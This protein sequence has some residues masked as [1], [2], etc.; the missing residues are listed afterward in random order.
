MDNVPVLKDTEFSQIAELVYS[1]F[2]IHL[3]EQKR[4]LVAGRLAKRLRDLNLT[5]YGDYLNF[6]RLDD[7]GQ[8]LTEFINR[9]TTN[10]SFFFR[11]RDHF[12]YLAKVIL[13][14]MKNNI[15]RN[16]AYPLR[17]WS[18]GCASGDEVYTVAML[19][20]EYFG[21]SFP[22]ID[23]GLLATDISLQA[24]REAQ[25]AV[26]GE[27]RLKELPAKYR[28]VWFNK[29]GD[30]QYA[31][32]S[33]IHNMVMFKRL[34]LMSEQFPFKGQFDL[35]LCRN[36][37][38]YFDQATRDKVVNS[39]YEHI[40]PGGHFFIGHSESLQRLSCPFEYVSPAI[41]R[42]GKG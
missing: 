40:K 37:M 31:L 41:Y 6:V 15:A 4:T 25:A 9:I 17:I 13:P 32:S 7:S 12:D 11:E 16:P 26:Y 1:R 3:S 5:S 2:G 36:V 14:E 22:K 28:S 30:D 20:R 34:N 27:A 24:L 42:K 38:I 35:V 39:I 19:I 29:V 8:E 23:C 33:D 21:T 10:H 18:A